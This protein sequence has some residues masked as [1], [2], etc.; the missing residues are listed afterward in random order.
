MD[1][2]IQKMPN[3]ERS[4]DTAIAEKAEDSSHKVRGAIV[5]SRL[6]EERVAEILDIATEIFIEQGFKGAS[7]NEIARRANA[8]K[9]TFYSRFP[10]KEELFIAVIERRMEL[11]FQEIAI[12]L[13]QD[14][15]MRRTL[16]EYGSRLLQFALSEK[17][18][19]LAR[20][21]SMESS[22]FPELGEKFYELGPGRGLEYLSSYFEGQI[23]IGRRLRREDPV[24]MAEHLSSLI[25]GGYA[26]WSI[27]G[28]KFKISVQEKR[29][30]L[31]EAVEVFLRAYA[32]PA[33]DHE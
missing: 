25:V 12:P 28:V 2:Q 13:P 14:A 29:K 3:T 26:R 1:E 30:R 17:Q 24:R 21:V 10:T 33:K 19:A 9:R 16:T 23:K 32:A 22:K 4:T 18:I 5:H 8:S 20:V 31:E 27:L 15:P 7:T 11:I 6:E